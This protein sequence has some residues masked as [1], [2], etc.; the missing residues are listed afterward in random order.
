M[1]LC[2]CPSASM[3]RTSLSCDFQHD[4]TKVFSLT[5]QLVGLASLLRW[6]HVPDHRVQLALLDPLGE[7]VPC[8]VHQV[9]FSRQISQPETLHAGSFR[10]QSAQIE[11]RLFAGSGS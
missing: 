3:W 6:K 1:S 8:L 9:A 4:L 10:I 2:V 11:L 5:Q 7:L